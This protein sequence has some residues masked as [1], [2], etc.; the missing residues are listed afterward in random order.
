MASGAA[1]RRQLMTQTTST[2]TLRCE[3]MA[4]APLAA[5]GRSLPMLVAPTLLPN[6]VHSRVPLDRS[7]QHRLASLFVVEGG[8]TSD[9]DEVLNS[10]SIAEQHVGTFGT[11]LLHIL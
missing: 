2:K 8:A 5:C 6:A 7:R 11:A 1:R 10:G 3:A 4:P 9:V